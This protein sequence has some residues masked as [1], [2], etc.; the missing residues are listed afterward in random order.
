MNLLQPVP[1]VRERNRGCYDNPHSGVGMEFDPLEVAGRGHRLVL[2]ECGFLKG[3]DWWMFPNAVSPF[4][5]LYYNAI[6]GHHVVFG[7]Q[8]I[9]LAPDQVMLIPDGNTFDT[10]GNQ[11]VDHFWMTFSL[12]YAVKSPG[13]IILPADPATVSQIKTVA[14]SFD[15]VGTGDRFAIYHGC[16]S[17]LHRL[18][19]DIRDQFQPGDRSVALARAVDHMRRNIA[20]PLHIGAVATI[21]G[22]SQRALSDHFQKEYHCSPGQFLTK[23]RIGEAASLLSSTDQNVDHIAETTGFSDRFYL[24]RVF[25]KMTGKS[26]VQYRKAHTRDIVII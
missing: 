8:L 24:S 23:L 16:H 22:V 19:V 13:A 12:G 9:P 6:P 17:L 11:P 7:K 10:Y 1:S 18:L 3:L 26:P 5:R 2:H 25:K 15:G 14:E 4:W 21:A 20:E